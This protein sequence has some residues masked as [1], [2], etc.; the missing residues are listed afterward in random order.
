MLFYTL[1]IFS[2]EIEACVVATLGGDRKCRSENI[3]MSPPGCK[4]RALADPD[5]PIEG[6][7]PPLL[8]LRGR[9]LKYS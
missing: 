6:S 9:P 8:P 5:S 1:M 7:N 3:G 4:M 2:R